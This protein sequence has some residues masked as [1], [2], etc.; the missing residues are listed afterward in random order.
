VGSL[1]SERNL[2]VHCAC[3]ESLKKGNTWYREGESITAILKG[4]VKIAISNYGP[5]FAE[6]VTTV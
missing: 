5:G 3:L 2:E 4:I 1:H 6:R